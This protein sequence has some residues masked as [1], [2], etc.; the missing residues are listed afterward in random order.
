VAGI[1]VEAA[2]PAAAVTP[3]AAT[4]ASAAAM[5]GLVAE[6]TVASATDLVCLVWVFSLR[7]KTVT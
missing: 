7:Q 2:T 1:R 5:A 3:A 4:A 6:A